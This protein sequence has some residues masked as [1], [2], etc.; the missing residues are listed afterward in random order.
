VVSG[1]RPDVSVDSHGS[2]FDFAA[3]TSI[4]TSAAGDASDATWT[5]LRAGLFGCSLVPKN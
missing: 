2:A 1:K 5:V 3:I 4:S